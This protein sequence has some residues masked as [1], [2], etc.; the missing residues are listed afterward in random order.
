MG[1]DVSALRAHLRGVRRVD[2][3]QFGTSAGAL[4]GEHS[5]E[6]TE[7][8]LQDDAIETGLLT[9]VLTGLGNRAL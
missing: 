5:P 4:V 7:A 6:V 2:C 8:L 3:D 9:D 1:S